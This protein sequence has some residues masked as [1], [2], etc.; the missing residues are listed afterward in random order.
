MTCP[1]CGVALEIG[2]WPF[3]AGGHGK[4][5]AR[6]N[7]DECDYWDMNLGPEPIHIRSWSQRRA[8]MAAQGLQD[9]GR[10]PQPPDDMVPNPQGATRW[11]AYRDLSPDRLAWIARMM[12]TGKAAKVTDEPA[13]QVRTYIEDATPEQLEALR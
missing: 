8:L 6:V 3:C 12:A 5:F 10:D 7:G 2:S 9:T 1:T 13:M 11:G 4:G